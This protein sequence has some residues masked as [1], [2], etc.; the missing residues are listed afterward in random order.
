MSFRTT[1]RA[2]QDI[3]DLYVQGASQFGSAQA[4]RYH[5][6]LLALFDLLADNPLIARLRTEFS[7]PV[8][9]HGYQA[10]MVVYVEDEQGILIVRVL[11]GRQD[12]EQVLS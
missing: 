4:E 12:W 10:H 1:R 9:M 6:G 5:A 7:P 2:E 3:T 8:R 11:H